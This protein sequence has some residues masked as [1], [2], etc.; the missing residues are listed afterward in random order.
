MATV[1]LNVHCRLVSKIKQ[2]PQLGNVTVQKRLLLSNLPICALPHTFSA[3][4]G[5]LPTV[6]KCRF[7]NYFLTPTLPPPPAL[8]EKY[9]LPVTA[10]DIALKL[11]SLQQPIRVIFI[12][13]S[14]PCLDS[15]QEIVL[16]S[17][18]AAK[19]SS[20]LKFNTDC[21]GN[22][23]GETNKSVHGY[24]S[25]RCGACVSPYTV[26]VGVRICLVLHLHVV[27]ECVCEC[28]CTS[29]CP[30]VCVCSAFC[31]WIWGGGSGET[32]WPF[33][34]PPLLKLSCSWYLHYHFNT[35]PGM[36]GNKI[37]SWPLRQKKT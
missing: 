17:N 20:A 26:R 8:K 35:L 1:C 29:V 24:K 31:V 37:F 16:C 30:C 3:Y 13:I 32:D 22:E 36:A 28:F 18:D 4:H 14:C 11:T 27:N 23:K 5:N 2:L 6:M 10:S 21:N 12:F 19:W 15:E 34:G 33:R 9:V 25:M 7:L